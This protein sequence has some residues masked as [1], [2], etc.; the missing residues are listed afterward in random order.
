MTLYSLGY[1]GLRGADDLRALLH[2]VPLHTIVDVRLQPFGRAPWN[3]PTATR[4]L[5]EAA[6]YRYAAAPDLGNLAYRTGGIEIKD[7]EAIEDVLTYLRAGQSVALLCVCAQPEGC[8]RWVLAEEA[9]RREPGLRVVHLPARRLVGFLPH[10]PTDADIEA[11]V[12]AIRR[13]E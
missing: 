13:S 4:R 12:E 9:V 11:F 2:D 5:V 10:D 6:G 7:I 3:G 1:S 8:H